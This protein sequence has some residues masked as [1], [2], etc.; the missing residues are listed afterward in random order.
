MS[1]T[2]DDALIHARHATMT[3]HRLTFQPGTR[4][5]LAGTIQ[6]AASIQHVVQQLRSDYPLVTVPQA[7]PLSPGTLLLVI[8]CY[9]TPC[10]NTP[11]ACCHVI[12]ACTC[13]TQVHQVR[14][15]D[16]RP[17]SCKATVT[18][19]SLWQMGAFTWKP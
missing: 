14:C 18:P 19:S 1:M 8:T 16:A 4:L 7:K 3:P 9:N 13:F 2:L 10:Y 6:F 17:L 5:T 15:W 11:Y 12:H